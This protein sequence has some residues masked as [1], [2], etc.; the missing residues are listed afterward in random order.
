MYWLEKEM[1]WAAL[2]RSPRVGLFWGLCF[3]CLWGVAACAATPSDPAPVL[4]ETAQP[5]SQ[6]SQ[7]EERAYEHNRSGM[8]N[9]SMALF[10]EAIEEFGLAIELARDYTIRDGFLIYTPTF[11]IAWSYEKIDRKEKACEHYRKFLETASPQ[12]IEKTKQD[13]AGQYLKQH[14]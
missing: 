10:D 9:M 6:F 2:S 11:M 12:W 5:P 7:F 1:F 3:F 4:P 13:H 8:V 14:C